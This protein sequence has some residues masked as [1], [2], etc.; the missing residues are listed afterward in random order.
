[1]VATST[2]SSSQTLAPYALAAIIA[3]LVAWF[4]LAPVFVLEQRG[5]RPA[6]AWELDIAA[7]WLLLV[8]IAKATRTRILVDARGRWSLSRLQL[9]LWTCLLLPT[10]WTMASVRMVAGAT[11]PVALGMDENL[12]LVLGISM[13]S[14]AT[15][16]LILQRKEVR[17]PGMLV[18]GTGS[19]P[20]DLVCGEDAGNAGYLDLARLQLLFFTGVS[21][22]VYAVACHH[23]LATAPHVDV[24]LP[25]VSQ[26]LVALLGISHATYLV[27]KNTDHP[28]NA[29][30]GAQ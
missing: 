13:T 22:C 18:R 23:A 27:N 5:W 16:P 17:A 19:N 8:G 12:W 28:A 20:S 21:V 26:S 3:P 2:P 25:P 30:G 14:F 10:L 15:S 6:S 29:R 4:V 1:M 9:V 7:A 24:A 11:D